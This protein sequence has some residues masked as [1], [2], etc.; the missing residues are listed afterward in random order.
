MLW[1]TEQVGSA[2]MH[3]M[4]KLGY[5]GVSGSSPSQDVGS[6]ENFHVYLSPPT[7]ILGHIPFK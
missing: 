2:R 7:Q 1:E 6:P 3:L 4:C 5:S